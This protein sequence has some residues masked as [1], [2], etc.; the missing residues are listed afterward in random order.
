MAE[1][2]VSVRLAAVGGRQVRAELEGVGEAGARGFGRLGREMEAANA[3]MAAFSRRVAVASAAAVAAASAAGVAMVR[4]GLASVDAQ[5]KLAQ[6]LGTTVASIQA[7]ERAGELA[8]VSMSGIEQATKDLTRRLSQAA[9]SGGPA[10]DALTRLG[11]SASD[12]L[13]MPLDQRVGAIN[14]AIESFVPV[15]E[16]AAVAGQ[17]FG[18]EGS[19]A[20]S[21][22][23]T[24]TLR[25]ATKDV[26]AF[27]VIVSEQDADQIERSNDAL[28]RLGLVWRGLSNQLAVAAAP[29]LEAVAN[30]MAVVSS[31]TGPLGIAI[32]GLFDNIGRLTSYA[33]TFSAFLA[34]RWV[35]GMAAAALSVR[36]LATALVVLRASLIRTG[37][38]AL[39]VGA[40][41][42]VYQFSRLVS[43]AGGFGK[44]MS[45]MGD[46][47]KAVWDGLRATAGSFADNF[48]AMQSEIEGI[49][50]RLMAFLTRKWADFLGMIAPTFNAVADEIGSDTR[51]DAFDALSRASYLDHAA[52]NAGHRAEHYRN[53]A[54]ATRA[55]AF[56]GVAPAMDALGTAMRGGGEDAGT[57]ALAAATT[58]AQ[59]YDNALTEAGQAATGAG[60]AAREAGIADKLAAEAATPATEAA[61][62]G[63]QAVTAALSDYASKA[64]EIGG[65]IG[66]TLVGAFQSAESAIGD[67]VKSGKLEFTDLVTSMIADLAKLAARRFILGPIANAMMGAMG[68]GNLFANVLHSG[69]MVGAGGPGRLVS[70]AAFASAPRMHAGGVAGLRHDEVPAILQRGERVLSRREAQG[71]GGVTVNIQARDAESFRQSRTQIASDIARAV[72]LGRRGL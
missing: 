47:A 31:R 68:S 35:A 16:R 37:I 21:R 34:S 4:S 24:A 9:A 32:T 11:L 59:A 22:I 10:A 29:A 19:I 17:L 14:A 33:A 3:R 71:Y 20:M 18:E 58:A 38:G 27:G 26:R 48:R 13:A 55:S 56:D 57:D 30:A 28:S 65:D 12:L 42:L 41:E 43:G 8:G 36:G 64:H 60:A 53:R 15:A 54:V 46:V 1:K 7:L 72:S 69:G 23:D 2:R 25:Q 52:S 50:T 66:Q 44:A 45:P 62:T 67:F 61:A 5:A 51:I 63:W 6:S 39:I 70:P 49:W 40:G